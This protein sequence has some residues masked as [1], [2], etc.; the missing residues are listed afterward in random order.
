[1]LKQYDVVQLLTDKQIVNTMTGKNVVIPAGCTGT[2]IE[3]YSLKGTGTG[4]EVEF[5]DNAGTSVVATV[6]G[7][8]LIAA[9]RS[10]G[11][12]RPITSTQA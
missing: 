3:I 7:E 4:Y 5:L 11:N 10:T 1:M 2:I 8:D 12:S 9:K 6:N